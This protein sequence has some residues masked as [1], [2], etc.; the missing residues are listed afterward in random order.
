MK[1]VNI[2]PSWMRQSCVGPRIRPTTRI[3]LSGQRVPP[4]LY[5]INRFR[6][7]TRRPISTSYALGSTFKS[8]AELVAKWLSFPAISKPVVR[9][10]TTNDSARPLSAPNDDDSV[11]DRNT[12]RIDSDGSSS[13]I[14]KLRPYQIDCINAVLDILENTDLTRLAI[15]SPTG[16]GK[17]VMFTALIPRVPPRICSDESPRVVARRVLIVVG[18]VH[19]VHQTAQTVKRF[20]PDASLEKRLD[21]YDP[22]TFKAVIIDKAHHS[23][24]ETY[25]KITRHFDPRLVRLGKASDRPLEQNNVEPYVFEHSKTDCKRPL[26]RHLGPTP[27]TMSP[28]GEPCVPIIGVSATLLRADKV[29]VGKV[30]EKI[31]WHASWLDMIAAGYLSKMRFT[32]VKLGNGLDLKS[33]R[34]KGKNGDFVL[35][36]LAEVVD[37]KT[38]NE[39]VVAVYKNK[40]QGVY[41]STVM[42]ACNIQ[43]TKSLQVEFRAQGVLARA[44]DGTT[45]KD[46]IEE[47]LDRFRAGEMHV[48]INCSKSARMILTSWTLH[49]FTF[50][51][52][53]ADLFMEGVD[54]PCIDSIM[55]VHPTHSWPRWLQMLGRGMRLSPETNKTHCHV[56]E[57]VGNA[58][59]G[60]ACS[61]NLLDVGFRVMPEYRSATGGGEKM[62]PPPIELMSDIQAHDIIPHLGHDVFGSAPEYLAASSP[63]DPS[64]HLDLWRST[65]NAWIGLGND[66]YVLVVGKKRQI[67]VEGHASGNGTLWKATGYE[68]GDDEDEFG[69]ILSESV[70][71]GKAQD[72]ASLIKEMD[73]LVCNDPD[74]RP[75]FSLNRNAQWRSEDPTEAQCNYLE[76]LEMRLQ[77][78]SIL[79]TKGR[80]SSLWVP[81]RESENAELLAMEELTRGEMTDAITRVKWGGNE[82]WTALKKRY[83]NC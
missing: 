23:V 34:R 21:S 77:D 8:S 46:E 11:T 44:V 53:A 14:V 13:P 41:T 59:D 39:I 76:M 60:L 29:S 35:K 74:W 48:L 71:L 33:V 62:A 7:D 45:S 2:F 63:D 79:S 58:T 19:L 4:P 49:S 12:S 78:Y 72:L 15:S 26:P 30:F 27:F 75:D 70:T 10:V 83:G 20:L 37:R 51:H 80:V 52:D 40:I 3:G 67:K 25:L 18:A 82:C 54:L 24:A 73:Q 66:A 9:H 64:G 17:T 61:P 6:L 57:F 68:D 81:G 28:N 50:F 55:A 38:V 31:V 36:A 65:P 32:T 5:F 56:F 16:S 47:V 43:H 42:Y 69:D 22:S 1:A